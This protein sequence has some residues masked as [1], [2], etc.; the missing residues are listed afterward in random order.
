MKADDEALLEM[1]NIIL[2]ATE[3]IS[4]LALKP[5]ILSLN[6]CFADEVCKRLSA[7]CDHRHLYR[8]TIP[9]LASKR[10][11]ERNFYYSA[12]RESS[13]RVNFELSQIY[14]RQISNFEADL[15]V[16]DAVSDL[17]N[18]YYQ[19]DGSI[20]TDICSGLFGPGYYWP[21]EFDISKWKKLNPRDPGYFQFWIESL[22][23][24]I[25]SG[26][27][28][29]ARI[30]FL[31]RYLCETSVAAHNLE[32]Q[33]TDDLPLLNEK[34]DRLY[35]LIKDSFPEITFV[36]LSKSIMLTS[37]D[38]PSGRWEFHP[39]IETL[40]YVS[41][42]VLESLSIGTSL[43]GEVL[44][45]IFIDRA[46]N[47]I[48]EKEAHTRV[49]AE[50]DAVTAERDHL[51]AE[52]AALRSDH[53]NLA[54]E[55][56]AAIFQRDQ[57]AADLLTLQLEH[58]RIVAEKDC[59]TS[60]REHLASELAALQSEYANLAT[61]LGGAVAQRDQDSTALVTVQQEHARI[62][63]ERDGLIGERELLTGELATLQS[64]YANLATELDAAIVQ[65]DQ[66][67]AAL[68]TVQQE[69]ARITAERD[70]LL[71]ERDHL[72]GE[73]AAVRSDHA[74]LSVEIGDALG[75]RDQAMTELLALQAE[76]ARIT[77]ERDDLIGERNHG[78]HALAALRSERDGAT[79]A[80][81]LALQEKTA[82]AQRLSEAEEENSSLRARKG[83][84][85]FLGL[86]K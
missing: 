66:H 58:A 82:L 73:L 37:E 74:N 7:I 35:K 29:K 12:H 50:R 44:R 72:V 79:A 78:I 45:P 38:A 9:M 15:I 10:F 6:G 2:S 8:V 83:W 21:D 76:Y 48:I 43:R 85:R 28:G 81:E 86:G 54:A 71:G 62:A 59:L 56:G 53:A 75:R 23:M 18:L 14:L 33:Q 41:Q 5:K 34:L 49:S 4:K 32:L 65:R 27:F 39:I 13:E 63:A 24:I 69:H 22:R 64:E 84:V 3:N 36:E 11:K 1:N 70:G 40:D 77:A 51:V 68:L 20:I 26:I 61:E 60:E 19:R 31:G 46:R 17:G 52:L 42:L 16:F 30:V 55:H 57:G 47:R 25:D 67:S 80:Y